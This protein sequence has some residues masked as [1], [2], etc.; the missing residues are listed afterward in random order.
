MLHRTSC[1]SSLSALIGVVLILVLGTGCDGLG[2][3]G[4]ART[5]TYNFSTSAQEWDS[6]FT[7]HPVNDADD[8]ELTADH[9][10]VPDSVDAT[11]SALYVHGVNHSDDLKMLF[12]RQVTGLTPQTTYDVAVTVQFLTSAPSHCPGIGGPEGEAVKVLAA[13]HTT[14]PERVVEEKE[15]DDWYRLNVQYAGDPQ[16]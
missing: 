2:N 9:R 6:L 15:P 3:D 7:D 13:A 14:K 11:G 8:M 1:S 12:R 5:I 10:A 4:D 16:A